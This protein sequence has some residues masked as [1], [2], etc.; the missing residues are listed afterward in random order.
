V[1]HLE[2]IIT[3]F[4]FYNNAPIRRARSSVSTAARLMIARLG[5]SREANPARGIR[6]VYRSEAIDTD[7]CAT[8]DLSFRSGGLIPSEN[9]P[10]GWAI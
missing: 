5:G 10:D 4:F 3:A 6:A 8:F 1:D 7:T 2:I 9:L